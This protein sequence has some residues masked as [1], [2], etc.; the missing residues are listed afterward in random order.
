MLISIDGLDFTGKTLIAKK[1]SELLGFQYLKVKKG[2]LK[3]Y[4]NCLSEVSITY[5]IIEEI[6]ES[7]PNRNVVLDRGYLS[8]IA[9]GMVY[10]S[11]LDSMFLLDNLPEK[12]VPEIG[13]IVTSS[14]ENALTRVGNRYKTLQD[15][16]VLRS[17]YEFYQKWMIENSRHKFI[18]LV[19]EY[20][21]VSDLYIELER[22]VENIFG[23]VIYENRHM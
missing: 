1:L 3:D 17:N 16:I 10:D 6:S 21:K 4:S 19:N 7:I 14:L 8:A 15:S 20:S 11:N 18:N 9:T 12:I 22:I 5:N 13:L 23:G 2:S